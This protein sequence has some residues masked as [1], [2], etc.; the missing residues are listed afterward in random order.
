MTGNRDCLA[1]TEIHSEDVK[2]GDAMARMFRFGLIVTVSALLILSV[3]PPA[4]SQKIPAGDTELLISKGTTIHRI[5]HV[6]SLP[7][8]FNEIRE[9]RLLA[10]IPAGKVILR[11]KSHSLESSTGK[12]H[13]VLSED[14]IWGYLRNSDGLYEAEDRIRGIMRSDKLHVMVIKDGL[15]LKTEPANLK[16]TLS[17]GEIYT[18]EKSPDDTGEDS[19]QILLGEQKRQQ[20]ANQNGLDTKVVGLIQTVHKDLV[21]ALDFLSLMPSAEAFDLGHK[22]RRKTIQTIYYG[23]RKY[24]IQSGATF[25]KRCGVEYQSKLTKGQGVGVDVTGDVNASAVAQAVTA[26]VKV[27]AE[28]EA[29]IRQEISEIQ[30]YPKDQEILSHLYLACCGEPGFF[31]REEET[32]HFIRL[33][34]KCTTGA[35]GERW[36]VIRLSEQPETVVSNEWVI[37]DINAAFQCELKFEDDSGHIILSSYNDYLIL[38]KAL[39]EKR[40]YSPIEANFVVSVIARIKN[41]AKFF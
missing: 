7:R 40:S 13:L 15:P 19:Y 33:I 2:G 9:D 5:D 6:D 28:F 21:T 10:V 31:S 23:V 38:V 8:N 29:S 24:R 14:G 30:A 20:I 12:R 37:K 26:S 22:N 25:V 39:V 36:H 27:K 34:A 17:R 41:S 1:Q 35:K 4:F 32:P 11:F 18:V 3:S 16:F